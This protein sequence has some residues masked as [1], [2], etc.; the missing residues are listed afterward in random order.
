MK[1]NRK[2]S[3]SDLTIFSEMSQLALQ[4]NAINLS[5]GF[6]DYEIDPVLKKLLANATN[7]NH[8]QYAPLQGNPLL[9]DNLVTFN[10]N[11]PFPL[12][13][14]KEEITIVPGATYA[15]YTTLATILQP[16]DEVIVFDPCYDS[17]VPAIE[18]NGGQPV[19]V[20]MNENFEIDWKEFQL[21][22]NDK[23][24][25]IIINSPNNPSGKIWSKESIEIFWNY[26]KDRDIIVI[27]DEVYDLLVY[28]DAKF[29]SAFHHE[30][31]RKRCFSIFSFGKMFHITGWKI[32][33]IVAP[34][35][36]STAFRRVHQYLTFCVNSPA[37]QALAEYI[38]YFDY[39]ENQRVMQSRRDL[40][41]DLMK[42]SPFKFHQPAKGSY[43]QTAS[44]KN[45]QPQM[46]D[47]EFSIWLTR[48]KKVASI[49]ISAFYHDHKDTGNIRFCFAKREETLIAAAKNLTQLL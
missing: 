6:P 2:H 12:K 32:G 14:N 49:P 29:Y 17:Y 31:I 28:D 41:L 22:I 19:F 46:S 5:Q 27:S 47:K 43:F 35:E 45:Y 13:I 23:T 39:K 16:G 20:Q 33:Y 1:I 11:R 37:Q 3:G 21:A 18:M 42:D 4:H 34:E 9:I 38:E 26:I 48:E 7:N 10:L 8:N 30:E 44:F 40:F 36:L 15:I 25:A 24:R